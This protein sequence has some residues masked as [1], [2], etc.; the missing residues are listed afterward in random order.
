MVILIPDRTTFERE[1]ATPDA[2][3]KLFPQELEPRDARV[4][5]PPEGQGHRLP[6]LVGGGRIVGE[7][8]EL[9]LDLVESV[10]KSLRDENERK[11]S[12]CGTVEAPMSCRIAHRRDQPFLFVEADGRCGEAGS[13][14]HPTNGQ[15]LRSRLPGGSVV[16]RH[17]AFFCGA[18]L[19]FKF[20]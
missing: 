2:A 11:A 12:Y 13:F 20:T 10:A 17:V 16:C 4:E 3:G 5:L 19:D 7:T 15:G 6:L 9:A 18:R 8:V 14:G 1:A